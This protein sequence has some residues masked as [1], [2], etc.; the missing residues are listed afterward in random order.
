LEK[1]R[2]ADV[3]EVFEVVVTRISGVWSG[4][5][6]SSVGSGGLWVTD[7]EFRTRIRLMFVAAEYFMKITLI[8][9]VFGLLASGGRLSVGMISMVMTWLSMSLCIRAVCVHLWYDYCKYMR[10]QLSKELDHGSTRLNTV[11]SYVVAVVALAA[12]VA[13]D[14]RMFMSMMWA[15][16]HTT[17]VVAVSGYLFW[18]GKVLAKK[19][20]GR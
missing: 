6:G 10:K 2:K 5:F 18:R 17:P 12:H 3:R 8:M 14:Y 1:W 7:K 4:F 19:A 9:L 15:L 13:I 16:L 11:L 20:L